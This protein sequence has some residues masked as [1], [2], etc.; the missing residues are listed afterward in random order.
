MSETKAELVKILENRRDECDSRKSILMKAI[1]RAGEHLTPPEPYEGRA[2]EYDMVCSNNER[3]HFSTDNGLIFVA[4]DKGDLHRLDALYAAGDFA[5]AGDE[6]SQYLIEVEKETGENLE[7][8]GF[9][10]A[11]AKMI[12]RTLTEEEYK[13]VYKNLERALLDK[14]R[15]RAHNAAIIEYRERSTAEAMA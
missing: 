13:T 5:K 2:R 4:S 10:K 11:I 14:R 9:T 12:T 1:S 15:E 7:S 6:L 3:F 8:T